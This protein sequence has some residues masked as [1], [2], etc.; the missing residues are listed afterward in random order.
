MKIRYLL[1]LVFLTMV[2]GCVSSGSPIGYV[3]FI[4]NVQSPNYGGYTDKEIMY[5]LVG[6]PHPPGYMEDMIAEFQKAEKEMPKKDLEESAI[7]SQ[8]SASW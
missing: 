8:T 3:E 6:P 5:A 2:T 1:I 4:R 7:G